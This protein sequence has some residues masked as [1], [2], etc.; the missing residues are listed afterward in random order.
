MY[1]D[2][3]RCGLMIGQIVTHGGFQQYQHVGTFDSS[4]LLVQT[5]CVVELLP[6]Y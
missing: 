6:K 3:A 5:K 1:T 4:S 2:V